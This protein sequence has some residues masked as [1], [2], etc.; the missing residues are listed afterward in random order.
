MHNTNKYIFI[1]YI[2]AELVEKWLKLRSRTG[3]TAPFQI[4]NTAHVDTC[5]GIKSVVYAG[6]GLISVEASVNEQHMGCE[7]R[8]TPS[9]IWAQSKEIEGGSWASQIKAN[10]GFI[11]LF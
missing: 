8:S 10:K 2:S 7:E 9:S 1:H 3:F 6:L 4:A 5:I 11:M